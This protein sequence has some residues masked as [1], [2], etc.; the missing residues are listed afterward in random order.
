MGITYRQIVKRVGL[1]FTA[2]LKGKRHAHSADANIW[3]ALV[4]MWFWLET[5]P[6]NVVSSNMSES[7]KGQR[8]RELIGEIV[9]TWRNEE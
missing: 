8:A 5:R 9:T 4:R 7:H 6:E 1:R 2:E 3:I